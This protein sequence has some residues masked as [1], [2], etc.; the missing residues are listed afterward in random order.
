MI[1][2]L[3]TIKMK[4]L[5]K[6]ITCVVILLLKL[7]C[8]NCSNNTT[9]TLIL[10]SSKY[11]STSS[12][13]S[14]GGLSP[15]EL[16]QLSS[17]DLV[18]PTTVHAIVL[19]VN[20]LPTSPF[21]LSFLPPPTVCNVLDE[22]AWRPPLL[23]SIEPPNVVCLVETLCASPSLLKVAPDH[24][25]SELI[26]AIFLCPK[27]VD[28]LRPSTVVCLLTKIA[29]TA[30][31]RLS[32]AVKASLIHCVL[33]PKAF[34]TLK[35]AEISTIVDVF[36][37]AECPL[38]G[39]TNPV[40]LI[41]LL[42]TIA[43]SP[44][45]G[46]QTISTSQVIAF[47]CR[48]SKTTPALLG[49]VPPNV[50]NALLSHFVE[51]SHQIPA[52][53]LADLVTV[54][55]S[56]PFSLNS[57]NPLTVTSLLTAL[58]PAS[59]LCSIP[60][61]V[62]IQLLTDLSSVILVDTVTAEAIVGLLYGVTCVS[63][64]L[65]CEIPTCV[66][67]TY[68]TRLT[69]PEV[70]STMS[71]E[72][73]IK[74]IGIL[75]KTQLFLTELPAS[76]VN[77]TATFM[78]SNETLLNATPPSDIIDFVHSVATS[79]VLREIPPDN[80]RKLLSI[81]N[82][83][84]S[85]KALDLSYFSKLLSSIACCP[86]LTSTLSGTQ[87]ANVLATLIS[88]PGALQGTSNSVYIGILT[89]LFTTPDCLSG[90][91]FT[92]ILDLLNQIEIQ[93]SNDVLCAIPPCAIAAFA[94][95]LETDAEAFTSLPPIDL[96]AL[97]SL[98]SKFNCIL[99]QLSVK[100]LS[101]LFDAIVESS[102]AVPL[103]KK[104]KLIIAIQSL[105]PSLLSSL[106]PEP[107]SEIFKSFGSFDVL[108]SLSTESLAELIIALSTCP[109]LLSN[110]DHATIRDLLEFLSTSKSTL[111]ALE[112]NITAN[113][114]ISLSTV[115]QLLTSIPVGCFV[116]IL[117]A[118]HTVL[119]T[120]SR[121]IPTTT[122]IE[123]LKSLT[124]PDTV[125]DGLT[126]TDAENL[127]D[128][129][130]TDHGLLAGLPP[131]VLVNLLTAITNRFATM[132]YDKIVYLLASVNSASP[133][134]LYAVP[135]VILVGILDT[136]GTR[137]V[138]CTLPPKCLAAF[139]SV[140][141]ASR[142]L[143]DVAPATMLDSLLGL[144]SSA[145]TLMATSVPPNTLADFCTN[146]ALTPSALKRVDVSIIISLLSSAEPESVRTIPAMVL[147]AL[148]ASL[149]DAKTVHELR[150][151]VVA[152]L[153][154]I[155]STTPRVLDALV[156]DTLNTIII[157]AASSTRLLQKLPPGLLLSFL[158]VIAS[159][160]LALETLRPTTVAHLLI[161]IAETQPRVLLAVPSAA[162]SALLLGVFGSQQAFASL[163]PPSLNGLI[164]ILITFPN[165]FASLPLSVLDD[166]LRFFTSFPAILGSILSCTL[167]KFL[168][169]LSSMPT[170]LQTLPPGTLIAFI[171]ALCTVSPKFLCALP[172]SIVTELFS[173]VTIEPALTTLTPS[174][175]ALLISALNTS[176]CLILTLPA[177]LLST[178][179]TYLTANPRLL[180]NTPRTALLT[181]VQNVQS[182]ES[183]PRIPVVPVGLGLPCLATN[184][185]DNFTAINNNHTVTT[186]DGK[187]YS[188]DKDSDTVTVYNF[189][190]EDPQ[191]HLNENH[192]ED[193]KTDSNLKLILPENSKGTTT[194]YEFPKNQ[195]VPIK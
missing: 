119:P 45:F 166:L 151:T 23:N 150:L 122:V 154:R 137:S 123:L 8:L 188:Y 62:L 104:I 46:N 55:T 27:I 82:S 140:L 37:S 13:L 102:L 187:T 144:L 163:P 30:L 28:A 9:T 147:Y 153:L 152:S 139:I 146:L 191:T 54:L 100:T 106:P 5:T 12:D 132:P 15:S 18:L 97:A 129:L 112:P 128:L 87:I 177:T 174:T 189:S 107:I 110:V 19:L 29:P 94:D 155:I 142:C 195:T 92:L 43:L 25:V 65:I 124:L 185:F 59:V 135:E 118:L 158:E 48:L 176:P 7:K 101:A 103:E 85:L 68:A 70:T 159:S 64:H 74:L 16:A 50:V 121:S 89:Q 20:A 83:M 77:A 40:D 136:I 96:T 108:G 61:A 86:Y 4:K 76:S 49:C 21:L 52:T 66:R 31:C 91:P 60:S 39:S 138:I 120:A 149:S 56:P 157:K 117:L 192:F 41:E 79:C 141:S 84:S 73:S 72:D 131:V 186:P 42:K 22:L 58:S 3:R 130:N 10:P 93:T 165:L 161:S 14:Y 182:P 160:R 71:I 1:Q 113:L 47:L 36:V 38:A 170:L 26:T 17:T 63:P 115:E 35:P 148:L 134:L 34:G 109:R 178:L 2:R 81:L 184:R 11:A 133:C 190:S 173:A 32:P 90:I 126:S 80:I 57:L 44:T 53:T 98:L 179:I 105:S 194:V 67:S 162:A 127:V 51:F 183:I 99:A 169:V 78:V 6:I 88:I 180:S 167:F 181:F 143:M 172:A 24:T 168:A 95:F 125:M 33:S 114:V 75:C 111:S 156:G 175:V 164:D 171:E 193:S 116:R 69:S 145:P